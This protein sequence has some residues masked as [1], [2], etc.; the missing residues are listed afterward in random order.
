MPVVPEHERVYK[1]CYY[2]VACLIIVLY[3]DNNGVRTNCPE[4]LEKFERDVKKDIRI[5]G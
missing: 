2:P 5:D 3:V 4:L 1:Q